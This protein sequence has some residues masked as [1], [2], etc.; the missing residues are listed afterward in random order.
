MN[1]NVDQMQNMVKQRRCYH[2]T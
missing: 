1:G 2:Q